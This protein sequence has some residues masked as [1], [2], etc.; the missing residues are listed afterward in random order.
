M[1]LHISG[2]AKAIFRHVEQIEDKKK[3][4]DQSLAYFD[5]EALVGLK[6]PLTW[7]T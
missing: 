1:N 5:L 7:W 2:V 3:A 6:V 4:G